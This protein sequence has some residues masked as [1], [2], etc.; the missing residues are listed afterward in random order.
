MKSDRKDVAFYWTEQEHS[1]KLYL[2]FSFK[3]KLLFY[4]EWKEFWFLQK[5]ETL[6]GT[7]EATLPIQKQIG[8]PGSI[9]CHK[10]ATTHY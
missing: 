8:F 6:E 7:L 4:L 1:K 10:V 3:Q 5:V 2:H 9:T